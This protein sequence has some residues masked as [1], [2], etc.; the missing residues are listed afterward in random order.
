M[1][2]NENIR[3]ERKLVEKIKGYTYKITTT[4]AANYRIQ[5]KLVPNKSWDKVIWLKWL[6]IRII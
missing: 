2:I 5:Q 6:I 4:P 3:N 1:N